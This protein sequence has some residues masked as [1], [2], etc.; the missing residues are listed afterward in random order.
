MKILKPDRY[1]DNRATS[2]H[3]VRPYRT[4]GEMV[5]TVLSSVDD[6][7]S[8]RVKLGCSDD[9]SGLAFVIDGAPEEHAPATDLHHYPIQM[10]PAG[11]WRPPTPQVGGDQPAELDH[12][13]AHG[14]ATGLDP[15]LSQQLLD[16]ANAEREAEIQPH[17]I[18]DHIR[19]ESMPLVNDAADAEAICEAV[20]RPTMRL[21]PAKSAE[22]Q[23]VLMLHRARELL[24]RQR[25]M[26][27]NAIRGHCAEFGIISPQGARRASDLI[28]EVHKD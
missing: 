11:R 14:L 8:A 1:G 22:R 3:A 27:I 7:C 10:P 13:A 18:A 9:L 15:A 24:V 6:P 16:V 19:R 12:P 2:G 26:L 23:G 5:W 17:R 21:V 20:T 25:T 4:I 28:D